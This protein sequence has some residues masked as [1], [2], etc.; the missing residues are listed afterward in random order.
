MRD[1]NHL[2]LQQFNIQLNEKIQRCDSKRILAKLEEHF[3]HKSCLWRSDT[4][5]PNSE[6]R[7]FF[8]KNFRMLRTL[9]ISLWYFPENLSIL[10]RIELEKEKFAWLNEKQKI[11]ISILLNSKE[12]MLKYLF[13]T[14]RYTGS[15]IFGNI[16]GNDFKELLPRLKVKIVRQTRARKKVFRRGPKDKGTRRSSSSAAIIQEE[17]MKDIYLKI[18][19]EKFVNRQLLLQ[20]TILRILKYLED[21]QLEE[22]FRKE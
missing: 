13:L 17:A 3:S 11:E 2:N 14:N 16:L 12:T 21:S 18:E 15:E 10:F 22:E 4:E 1:R 5:T 20:Q 6:V 8:P 19:E 9:C 7:V